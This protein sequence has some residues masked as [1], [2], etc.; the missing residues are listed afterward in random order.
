[1]GHFISEQAL[2][3]QEYITRE[4]NIQHHTYEEEMT[5]FEFLRAGDP[6]AM[7]EYAKA[8][9]FSPAID[10]DEAFALKYAD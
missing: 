5:Q 4:N 7:E 3:Y 8:T 1:M 9:G 6:R 2:R 10:A